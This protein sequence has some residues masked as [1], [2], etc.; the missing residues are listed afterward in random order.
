MGYV[1]IVSKPSEAEYKQMVS[2]MLVADVTIPFPLGPPIITGWKGCF[3][4]FHLDELDARLEGQNAAGRTLVSACIDFK[5]R[6][7][8]RALLGP[9]S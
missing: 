3:E 5:V 4:D 6:R 7:D 8:T 9:L 1:L 2:D